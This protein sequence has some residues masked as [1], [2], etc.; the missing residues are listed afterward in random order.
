MAHQQGRGTLV[1]AIRSVSRL[2]VNSQRCFL[3]KAS[4]AQGTAAAALQE[5]AG[6]K[7]QVKTH[8]EGLLTEEEIMIRDSF[9]TYRQE[10]LTSCIIMA[11]RNEVFHREIVS[12]MGELGVLGPT[13]KGTHDIHTLIL[14]RAITGLQ[15][16]MVEKLDSL[17]SPLR[18]RSRTLNAAAFYQ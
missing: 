14:G 9:R 3:F 4:R 1:M 5:K 18:D 7:K 15:S 11:N 10:K 8:P 13:I 16:F 17:F 12:E 6:E 2:L